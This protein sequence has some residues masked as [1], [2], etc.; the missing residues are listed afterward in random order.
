MANRQGRNGKHVVQ[1]SRRV[2]TSRDVFIKICH[3][4]A[5][6][7]RR[8]H[9]PEV[10]SRPTQAR[11]V[12]N[13]GPM[14]SNRTR[15]SCLCCIPI[16][17]PE[18]RVL[19]NERVGFALGL[20]GQAFDRSCPKE[21]RGVHGKGRGVEPLDGPTLEGGEA[22]CRPWVCIDRDAVILFKR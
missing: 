18:S 21:T 20:W 10:K 12:A 14:Y 6:D 2:G 7:T 1:S 4:K 22:I 15:G 8:P 17:L 19:W 13:L 9:C 11:D 5:S 3:M 16:A